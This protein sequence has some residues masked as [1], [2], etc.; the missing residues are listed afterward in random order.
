MI[1]NVKKL[2]VAALCLLGCSTSFAQSN[3]ASVQKDVESAVKVD[4]ITKSK[5]TLVFINKSGDFDPKLHDK[6]VDVFFTNYPKQVKKYNKQA[7]RKV[8]FVI[9]PEYTGVAAAASGI[10]RFNPEWFKKNP[11]DIDVVTHETM[12]LVQNYPNH[13]GPGWITEGIADYVRYDMGVDNAGANWKLPEFNEAHS[14]E[15]AYRIT[16][17][18][19]AWIE[20]HKQKGI[21]QKLDAVMRNKQYTEDFWKQN[22]GS[23]VDELWAEYAQNP[24]I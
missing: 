4:T 12:H 23:N 20:K 1:N 19:F 11:G 8:I 15:N 21:V 9:D 18:F 6:L 17:R 24:V 3:W 16:A 10:I 5:F 22:T 14:Y 2:A 13:A 7:T